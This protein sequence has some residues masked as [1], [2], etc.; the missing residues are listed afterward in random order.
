MLLFYY[1]A[2][3]RQ[4]VKEFVLFPGNWKIRNTR[5]LTLEILI[6]VPFVVCVFTIFFFS[7]LW[8]VDPLL[9]LIWKS[10][11]KVYVI[12]EQLWFNKSK[13]F[14]C[15]F[16]N[17]FIHTVWVFADTSLLFSSSNSWECNSLWKICLPLKSNY[18]FI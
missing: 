7:V 10:K 12:N 4:E 9:S 13:Q 15:C 16:I 5:F 1:Y 17:R 3:V 6:Q 8:T 2:S 14:S 18:L 11:W